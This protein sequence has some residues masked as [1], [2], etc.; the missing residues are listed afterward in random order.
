MADKKRQRVLSQ[1]A[2]KRDLLLAYLSDWVASH[3]GDV[4]SMSLALAE[5]LSGGQRVGP[6]PSPGSIMTMF[7]VLGLT[8]ANI[9]AIGSREKA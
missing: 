2:A 8:E 1:L 5:R 3:P 4:A 9:A 6:S 7:A